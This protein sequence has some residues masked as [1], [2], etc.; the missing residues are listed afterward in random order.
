MREELDEA[1]HGLAGGAIHDDVDSHAELWGDNLRIASKESK[2]LLLG[3]GVG[4][5]DVRQGSA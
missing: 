5:L 2:D 3:Q 1:V 4:D